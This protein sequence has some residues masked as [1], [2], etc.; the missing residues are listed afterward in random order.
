MQPLTD[1]Y[2]LLQCYCFVSRY[3]L[4]IMATTDSETLNFRYLAQAITVVENPFISTD[5]YKIWNKINSSLSSNAVMLWSCNASYE[6]KSIYIFYCASL[7]PSTQAPRNQEFH[8]N[9]L[10][11]IQDTQGSTRAHQTNSQDHTRSIR[12]SRLQKTISQFQIPHWSLQQP[13]TESTR[14]NPQRSK[15]FGQFWPLPK[16]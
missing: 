10:H 4:D 5:K 11:M 6:T 1:I 3:N 14:V 8:S 2:T 15:I 13:T 7:E 9:P 12:H 16:L